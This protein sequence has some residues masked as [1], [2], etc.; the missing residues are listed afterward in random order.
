MPK[1]RNHGDGG[2]YYV[3]QQDLWRGVLDVGYHPDGRRKQKS[4]TA[5]TQREARAKLDKLKAE[6]AEFG[7][8]L[9]NTKTV[10]DWGDYWLENVCRQKMK[11]RPFSNY[12]SALKT[13]IYP[14]IGKKRLSTLKPSDIR[15]TILAPLTAGRKPATAVKIHTVLSSMLE[16][17]RKDGLVARNV[18]A[19]VD[20]PSVGESSR[21]ALPTP[22]AL[23][24]LQQALA[25]EDG[26]RWWV[27]LLAGMRQG[28]RLGAT[29][30]SI[31]FDK[32][33][34]TVQWSLTEA[35]F[36]HGCGG[37]CRFK[38]AGSCPQRKMVLMPGLVHRPLSG[39]LILVR[40]KSG[41]ARVFPL[42]PALEDALRRYLDATKDR[43]NPHGLIWRNEDGSPIT[44]KQDSEAWRELLFEAGLI[45][46]EQV[47]APKDRA[48]GTADIPTTHWARHTTATVLMELGV[49]ARIVGE[50]VGHASTRVTER[51]QHVSSE[52][53]RNA[54][55]AL[56]GHFAKALEA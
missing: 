31:D 27:A 53:A 2:L 20:V 43:P 22:A 1:K 36:E 28:E 5:R 46:E 50:I 19:D 30:D 51:Y 7:A 42:I 39:R 40:P 17:A 25:H 48:V 24:I 13:W 11:P 3:K 45:T 47:K 12:T 37:E 14:A 21:D 49:D 32:H 35:T 15:D 38:R 23:S 18:A 34:F 44:W 29:I 10:R 41:K 9:D 8:P 55:N 54:M 16:A 6:I 26:T 4:V 56:G 33:E 52:A